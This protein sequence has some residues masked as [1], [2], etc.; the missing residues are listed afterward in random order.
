MSAA[1]RR[2]PSNAGIKHKCAHNSSFSD[3][4]TTCVRSDFVRAEEADREARSGGSPAAEHRKRGLGAP[5]EA[6]TEWKEAR[7]WLQERGAG[8]KPAPDG[9]GRR[10]KFANRNPGRASSRVAVSRCGAWGTSHHSNRARVT[11]SQQVRQPDLPAEPPIAAA[12]EEIS[13]CVRIVSRRALTSDSPRRRHQTVFCI[14]SITF[15]RG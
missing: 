15:S 4:P 7:E 13:S 12:R 3:T 9:R 1:A 10:R 11:A 5:L 2:I 14:G 8:E 6:A